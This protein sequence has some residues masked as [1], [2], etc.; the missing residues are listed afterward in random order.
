MRHVFVDTVGLLALWDE[1]DQWHAAAETA[2]RLVLASGAV[3]CTTDYVLGNAV[4]RQRGGP[5][6][7]RWT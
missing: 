3:P 2:W 4:T 7:N 6:V 5:I 1:D